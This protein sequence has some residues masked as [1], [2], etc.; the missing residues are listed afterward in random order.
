MEIEKFKSFHF[1]RQNVHKNARRGASGLPIYVKHFLKS[2]V[3]ILNKHY[4]FIV[5]LCIHENICMTDKAVT[6][7]TVYFPPHTATCNTDREDYLSA[8]QC[9]IGKYK[10][11]Y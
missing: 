5:W 11:D 4:D 6:I 1:N 3:S 2:Y 10:N 9:G 8:L 7:G